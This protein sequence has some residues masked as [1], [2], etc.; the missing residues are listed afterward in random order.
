MD[1]AIA[2]RGV[3]MAKRRTFLARI[4]LESNYMDGP[5]LEEE[6]RSELRNYYTK[7]IQVEA[8]EESD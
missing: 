7:I 5:K 2:Y 1:Y 6:I 8:K 4:E 3:N